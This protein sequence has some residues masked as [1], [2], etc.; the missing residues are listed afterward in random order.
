MSISTTTDARKQLLQNDFGLR[1][2]DNCPPSVSALTV[3]NFAEAGQNYRYC[4]NPN[5]V[6]PAGEYTYNAAT[7]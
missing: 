2:L 4:A 7:Q 5:R 1:V 6:Y 3:V